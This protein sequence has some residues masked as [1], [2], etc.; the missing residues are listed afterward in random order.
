MTTRASVVTMR[1][2]VIFSLLIVAT[3]CSNP[4]GPNG[5]FC[6]VVKRIRVTAD[7]LAG[8]AAYSDPK[9]LGDGMS[10]RV[11]AYRD[12]AAVAPATIQV[13]AALVR[14]TI[15]KISVALAAAGNKS[16]A[17]NDPAISVLVKDEKFLTASLNVQ[18]FSEGACKEK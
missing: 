4:T 3:S 6:D 14:D 17:A 10:L 15:T 16:L 13:D 2:L 12:L 5:K 1:R 7:P 8:G 11:Q 9:V 18:R